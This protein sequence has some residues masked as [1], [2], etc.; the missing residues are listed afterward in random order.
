MD[1]NYFLKGN[2]IFN[3]NNLTF[4]IFSNHFLKFLIGYNYYES[5]VEKKYK[6]NYYMYNLRFIFNH[7]LTYI[8]D[9]EFNRNQYIFYFKT[10]SLIKKQ[11]F[12]LGVYYSNY[13]IKNLSYQFYF[14]NIEIEETYKKSYLLDRSYSGVII[15]YLIQT[16]KI[17]FFINYLYNIKFVSSKKLDIHS[18]QTKFSFK[19]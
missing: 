2:I 18:I 5:I 3:K 4:D 16:E 1:I 9:Y 8:F 17:N 10:N 7:N 19:F 14:I 6:K 11:R 13:N 12:F 15:E